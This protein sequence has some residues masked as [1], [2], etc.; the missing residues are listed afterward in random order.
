MNYDK[1]ETI[2]GNAVVCLVCS[3]FCRLKTEETGICGVRKNNKGNGDLQGRSSILTT[4]G[5]ENAQ[6]V[7]ERELD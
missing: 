7:I 1:L 4:G 2:D 3:H 6:V 5:K